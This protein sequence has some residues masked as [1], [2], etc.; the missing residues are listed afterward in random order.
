MTL[1][2]KGIGWLSSQ[3]SM[4]NN[5]RRIPGYPPD[6]SPWVFFY[7]NNGLS[8]R[9]DLLD[10]IKNSKSHCDGEE[11]AHIGEVSTGALPDAH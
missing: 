1:Q 5:Y 11:Q 3:L 4:K 7:G 9:V 8:I 10:Y 2:A 6:G